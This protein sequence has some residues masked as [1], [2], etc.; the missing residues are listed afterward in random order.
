MSKVNGVKL[1]VIIYV[2]CRLPGLCM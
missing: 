1:Y 2:L